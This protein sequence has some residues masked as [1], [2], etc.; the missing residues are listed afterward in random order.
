MEGALLLDGSRSF[1][2]QDRGLL[3]GDGAREHALVTPADLKREHL[4]PR[5][6]TGWGYDEGDIQVDL[7]GVPILQHN[8]YEAR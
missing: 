3:A 5:Q 8:W 1:R 7:V 2:Q 4:G 6:F